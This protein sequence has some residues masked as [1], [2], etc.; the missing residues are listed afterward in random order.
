MSKHRSYAMAATL[1]CTMGYATLAGAQSVNTWRGDAATDDWSN[2]Y[3]WKLKHAPQGD[4]VAHFR[5][6]NSAVTINSTVQLNNGIHLYGQ[7]LLLSGNGNINLWSP[8][9]HQQTVSIP[10]SA[11][12][13]ANMTLADN[14]SL[15]GR[16]ALSATAFGTSA[17]KGSVTLK[18]RSSITGVLVI[19]NAGSGSGQVY[20][21]D[22]A[23]YRITGLELSTRAE[24]GGSAE[25]H[26]LGGTARIET[27]ENPF[28]VFMDDPSRK[29]VLGDNGTLRIDSDIPAA[30]KKEWIKDLIR[31]NRLVAAPGCRL[32]VP[33]F[34]DKVFIAKAEDERNASDIKTVDALLA[35]IDKKAVAPAPSAQ[36]RLEAL[37]TS[38]GGGASTSPTA[39]A[40]IQPAPAAEPATKLA[41]YIVFF[42]AILLA[43]RRMPENGQGKA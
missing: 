24:S 17:S 16:I 27:K 20:I 11:T 39:I 12:G 15:N 40:A 35:A 31:K 38:V 21:K 10:A 2:P 6:P 19:G 26:V 37:L 43:F 4:E 29:I 5:E 36:P 18:D 42:G 23:T 30:K 33:L 32:T 7:E 8:V 22:N 14:L 41:G 34:D 3:K 28:A 13:Y 1:V 9:P 25:I